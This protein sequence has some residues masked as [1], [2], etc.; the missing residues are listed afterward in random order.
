MIVT[1]RPLDEVRHLRV[2]PDMPETSTNDH[3]DFQ[4]CAALHNAIVKHAWISTGGDLN[5]L[6][7]QH[8]WPPSDDAVLQEGQERL[9]S[10]VISFLERAIYHEEGVFFQFIGILS[11][12]ENLWEMVEDLDQ[13]AVA[14][15]LSNNSSSPSGADIMFASQMSQ[16]F[17][18]N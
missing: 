13:D 11:G 8:S 15:Y 16:P 17:S 4:R 5:D 6:P 14:L 2:T 9:H 7:I 18:S 10:D 3:L 1:S 12:G